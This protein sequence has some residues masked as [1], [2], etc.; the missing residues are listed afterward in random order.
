MSASLVPLRPRAVVADEHGEEIEAMDHP[1][2]NGMGPRP[3]M[4]PTI[5]SNE[6]SS[7]TGSASVSFSISWMMS[8]ASP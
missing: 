8:P 6:I 4:L 7:A 1:A 5:T 3:S 2:D